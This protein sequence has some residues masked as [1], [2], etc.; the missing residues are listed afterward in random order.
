M[1]FS[2]NSK[3]EISDNVGKQ[4]IA[5]FFTNIAIH[6][7]VP[8][9]RTLCLLG[10]PQAPEKHADAVL[11]THLAVWLFMQQSLRVLPAIVPAALRAAIVSP[12]IVLDNKRSEGLSLSFLNIRRGFKN[13]H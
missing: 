3:F 7:S 9:G 11:Q 8:P 1:Q 4:W 5:I 2:A 12:D 10:T 13:H 6:R